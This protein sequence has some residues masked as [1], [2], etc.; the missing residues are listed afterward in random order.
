MG[1]LVASVAHQI[2]N[3]LA[4]IS[5]AN[6]LLADSG[7]G[8]GNIDARLLSSATTCAGSTR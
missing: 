6:E 1:R 7:G 3:P 5:Q 2:R 8:E 4:A